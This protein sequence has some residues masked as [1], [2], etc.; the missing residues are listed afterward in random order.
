METEERL[1]K[2]M[3]NAEETFLERDIIKLHVFAY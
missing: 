1:K 2:L 3:E